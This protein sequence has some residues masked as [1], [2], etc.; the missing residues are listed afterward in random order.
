MSVQPKPPRKYGFNRVFCGKLTEGGIEVVE[1]EDKRELFANAKRMRMRLG[2]IR[3][4]TRGYFRMNRN[5][6]D[7]HYSL[8]AVLDLIRFGKI[9]ECSIKGVG[10]IFCRSDGDEKPFLLA[11]RKTFLALLFPINQRLQHELAHVQQEQCSGVAEKQAKGGL[12]KADL[13]AMEAIAIVFGSFW[14]CIGTSVLLYLFYHT[15]CF[16]WFKFG[17]PGSS[18]RMDSN[19]LLA[20]LGLVVFWFL[21]GLCFLLRISLYLIF[22]GR[23]CKL[24]NSG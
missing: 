18:E 16:L 17:I 14:S 11:E 3:T 15:I 6:K 5:E 13:I 19:M 12:C 24:Y 22:H 4:L 10:G 7:S 1:N 9:T 23:P 21:V 8:R 2:L 20:F